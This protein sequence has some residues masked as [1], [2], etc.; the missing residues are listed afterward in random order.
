[1]RTDREKFLAEM[2]RVVSWLRLVAVNDP[3]CV[4]TDVWAVSPKRLLLDDDLTRAPFDKINAHL[5]DEG[6]LMS[7]DTIVDATI[8]A[9]PSS[10]KSAGNDRPVAEIAQTLEGS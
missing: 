2:E 6:L 9:A 4:T 7:A 10:T 1:M 5:A 8:I 3:L